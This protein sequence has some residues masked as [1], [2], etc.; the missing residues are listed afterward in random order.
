MRNNKV[1]IE[2]DAK[3]DGVERLTVALSEIPPQVV[4]KGCRDCEITISPQ[5]TNYIPF[6]YE[7]KEKPAEPKI[8]TPCLR[9]LSPACAECELYWECPYIGEEDKEK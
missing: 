8:A 4:I 6:K 7:M 2:I 9:R 5:Q 1:A 3:V